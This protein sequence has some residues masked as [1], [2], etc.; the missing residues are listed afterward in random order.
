MREK[1]GSIKVEEG[2]KDGFVSKMEEFLSWATGDYEKLLDKLKKLES[3]CKQLAKDFGQKEFADDGKSVNTQY[4]DDLF[5][6]YT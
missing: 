3:D 4:F 2:F 6:F 5:K 1:K